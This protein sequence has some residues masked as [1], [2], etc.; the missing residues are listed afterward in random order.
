[1][2][3]NNQPPNETANNPDALAIIN[4]I[5]M[6]QQ[7]KKH[8]GPLFIHK[9]DSSSTHYKTK[10]VFNNYQRL[11][12]HPSHLNWDKSHPLLTYH[13]YLEIFSGCPRLV[14]ISNIQDIHIIANFSAMGDWLK[15]QIRYP[16]LAKKVREFERSTELQRKESRAYLGSFFQAEQTFLWQSINIGFPAQNEEEENLEEKLQRITLY[17]T[18]LLSQFKNDGLISGHHCRYLWKIIVSDSQLILHLLIVNKQIAEDG[19]NNTTKQQMKDK[20]AKQ[21]DKVN[22]TLA[23]EATLIANVVNDTQDTTQAKRASF[24]GYLKSY[25]EQDFWFPY[26]QIACKAPKK[27]LFGKGNGKKIAKVGIDSKIAKDS[28]K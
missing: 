17:R 22:D 28:L 24:N 13:P 19:K 23:I 8:K 16:P 12:Y 18:K 6:M 1:M 25:F 5:R 10:P 26:Y 14:S 15:V 2:T 27:M 3:S 21:I 4:I 11:S 20:A 9:R 7:L